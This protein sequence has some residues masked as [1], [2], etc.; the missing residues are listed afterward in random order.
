[1]WC[2]VKYDIRDLINF[3]N[4]DPLDLYALAPGRTAKPT[5]TDYDLPSRWLERHV[6]FAL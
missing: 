2:Q 5:S 4:I 3:V 1:M 6:V